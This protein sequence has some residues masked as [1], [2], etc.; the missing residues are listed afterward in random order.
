MKVDKNGRFTPYLSQK[1]IEVYINN[2]ILKYQ[3]V[4]EVIKKQP[5]LLWLARAI[6]G[7]DPPLQDSE[8]EFVGKVV[9]QQTKEGKDA[10]TK[11]KKSSGILNTPR[12]NN[13]DTPVIIIVIGGLTYHEIVEVSNFERE[14]LA[15]GTWDKE[16]I[17]LGSV[18]FQ[19]E[20]CILSASN[21]I[22]LV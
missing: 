17:I 4:F 10:K 11:N 5:R 16:R 18:P 22:D 12:E 13:H 3:K 6:S 15:T 7:V 2:Y 14:M 1:E 21:F 19:D 9:P 8:F 20:G